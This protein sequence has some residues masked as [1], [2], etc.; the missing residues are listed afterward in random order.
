MPSSFYLDYRNIQ[1]LKHMAGMRSTSTGFDFREFTFW[2]VR[3]Q[4]A[5]ADRLGIHITDFKTL[6]LLHRKGAMTPKNL[7]REIAVT[8]AAMTTIVDRLEKAAYAR[9]KRENDD[10]RVVTVYATEDSF[11]RVTELYRSLDV[12]GRKLNSKYSAG[13]LKMI[14]S[15]LRD[16]TAALQ[17]AT[18]DLL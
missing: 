9:R 16:A 17:A 3:H 11:R 7:A 18:E 1:S 6:G 8:P 12:A 14:L 2:V 5:I 10:H 15:Y 13:E 4:Q